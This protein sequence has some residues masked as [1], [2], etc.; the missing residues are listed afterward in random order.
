MQ[1]SL[2]INYKNFAKNEQNYTDSFFFIEKF[3]NL[4]SFQF[5]FSIQT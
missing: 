3:F 4:S 2:F 1:Q 5:K